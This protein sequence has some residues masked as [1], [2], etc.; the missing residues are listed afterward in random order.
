MPLFTLQLGIL[1]NH[2]QTCG[3][4]IF[5]NKYNREHSERQNTRVIILRLQFALENHKFFCLFMY[6]LQF[7]LV[8]QFLFYLKLSQ[9]NKE[10]RG[11]THMK[12]VN[13]TSV[14][15]LP[16]ALKN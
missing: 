11:V 1:F 2:Y 12:N 6:S 5:C 13:N 15:F 3:Y 16:F 10:Y 4:C 8:V 7:H 14:D 9:S